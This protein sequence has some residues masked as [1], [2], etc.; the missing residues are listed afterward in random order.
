MIRGL[1]YKA[2]IYLKYWWYIFD[3]TNLEESYSFG[4]TNVGRVK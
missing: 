1:L 4:D 3:V 2:L